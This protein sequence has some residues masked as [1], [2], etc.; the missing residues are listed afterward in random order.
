[1]DTQRIFK[2]SALAAALIVFNPAHAFQEDYVWQERF[3]TQM[4]L[5]EK[6]NADAQ[7][8]IG[9]MLEKGSG[10]TADVKKAFT[11]FE[12]AA[13]QGHTKA[14]FKVAF[15]YY[16]GQGV[17]ADVRKAFNLM[18]K[19][20]N[21]GNV[22]AQFYLG[23]MYANGEGVKQDLD[24]A[25]TWYSRSSLGGFK[26]ADEALGDLKK[27]MAERARKEKEAEDVAKVIVTP[28]K[29]KSAPAKN[30]AKAETPSAPAATLS[31]PSSPKSEST[32][33]NSPSAVASTSEGLQP[34]VV[35]QPTTSNVLLGGTWNSMAKLPAEF[36]PSKITS[37]HKTSDAVIECLSDELQRNIAGTEI[38]YQTKAIVYGMK[39]DGEFKIAY[40][41][42]VMKI[43]NGKE[44]N[45]DA[46]GAG[47]A[48]GIKLGW[49]ETEHRLECKI[50]AEQS[51]NCVK[52]KT[53][54]VVLK[55]QTML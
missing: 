13:A 24:E 21:D 42:N 29:A 18:E 17:G 44:G 53:Q 51:I 30:V 38:V 23:Q 12:R 45:E 26:P 52:N 8:D 39:K 5:A 7:Y 16:K 2:I 11:W 35:T 34:A 14:Q 41:N 33:T 31:P 4:P 50:E 55:N 22:R 19:P 37:C 27:V 25:F 10:T 43:L 28:P 3:R 32:S 48:S 36:L 1:M 49:Q 15:M 40:R 20:A 46:S 54:K 6:G 9:E 47:D